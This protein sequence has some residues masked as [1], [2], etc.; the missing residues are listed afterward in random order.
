LRSEGEIL[1]NEKIKKKK[2]AFIIFNK[3]WKRCDY[4]I[5]LDKNWRDKEKK[6]LSVYLSDR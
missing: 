1:A 3:K 6:K 4:M 2:R 5:Y